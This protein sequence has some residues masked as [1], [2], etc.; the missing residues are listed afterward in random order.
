MSLKKKLVSIALPIALVLV[1]M[2][3]FTGCASISS[4]AAGTTT[5]SNPSAVSY[6]PSASGGSLYDESTVTALYE[7]AIPA[8]VEIQVTTQASTGN[9]GPFQFNTPSQKGLGSG[10]FIDGNG[11][12]LTN[13]HVVQNASNVKV[14]FQDGK[15]IDAKVIGT[16]PQND[17][18]IVQVNTGNIGQV[19]YLPL[20]N[21]DALKPGQMAIAMGSPFGLQG[22]ITV[23]IISGVGR[24]LPGSSNSR[25]IVNV[26]QTD[27]SINPGNS[28]G[29]LFNSKGEVIGI[30]TAIEASG[31]NVGFAIPINT[32][33]SR[34]PILLK[35]GEAKTPW[36]GITG[37]AIDKDLATQLKLSVNTGVY[38]VGVASGSPAEKAGLK[39]G[40]NDTA[41]NPTSGGD[42]VTA[43]DGKAITRTEDILSYLNGKAP[44]DVIML[45][46]LRGGSQVTIPVTLGTWPKQIA[47]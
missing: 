8:V 44:G 16:D 22:S 45:S 28:G 4:P 25:T 42:I 34:L 30:N 11:D 32:A 9:L 12:I 31:S 23:G 33:K 43:I 46:V 19:T 37:A 39:A 1:L 41:G 27:A 38:I 14:T 7:K 18:A 24:S 6:L 35:G 20:G 5:G 13:N 40:S 47:Q 26:I 36:I 3:S 10:F 15:T 17:L 29:P 21:S 2:A